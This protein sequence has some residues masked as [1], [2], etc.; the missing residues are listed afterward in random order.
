LLSFPE[1]ENITVTQNTFNNLV[2]DRKTS[3]YQ[4]AIE[5]AAML[6]LNYRPDISSGQNHVFSNFI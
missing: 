4:E 3:R 6:L 1:L 5:I 2:F